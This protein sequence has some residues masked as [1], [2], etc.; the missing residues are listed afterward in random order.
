MAVTGKREYGEVSPNLHRWI[1]KPRPDILAY[2]N[3]FSRGQR[4]RGGE[5]EEEEE[6]NP[7][8]RALRHASGGNCVTREP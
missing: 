1:R 8:A 7:E 5:E 4:G 2:R 6:E 3:Q